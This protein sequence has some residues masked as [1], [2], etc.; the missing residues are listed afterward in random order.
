MPGPNRP[1]IFFV[2][3]GRAARANRKIGTVAISP[4]SLEKFLEQTQ[5]SIG[6]N[7]GDDLNG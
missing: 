6:L 2:H 4:L 7:P 5:T 1:G 3:G